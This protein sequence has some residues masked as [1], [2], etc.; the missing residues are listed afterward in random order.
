VDE[1]DKV[2]EVWPDNWAA[3]QTF[4]A[5]STQWRVGAGGA[6]GL[7]YGAVPPVMRLT[8][9]PRGDWADVF[10]CIRIME[11]AALEKLRE[12]K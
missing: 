1:A 12:K 6:T 5:L 9:V 4:A 7:D 3:V 11:V 8:G 2:V 10:D